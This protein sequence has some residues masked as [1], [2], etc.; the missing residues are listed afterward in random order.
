[1]LSLN[2]LHITAD[3]KEIVKGVTLN[4][5]AGEVHVI[6]GPNGS[7]KSTLANTIMGHPKYTVTTGTITFNNKDITQARP[8][9]RA[10]AG[11]FL[12]MQYPPS[13]AGVT[14]SQFLRAAYNATHTPAFSVMEF[15]KVLREKIDELEIDR[16][17]IKRNINEGFSGGEK[18]RIEILQLLV[19]EPRFAILDETDSGLDVDALK[20]V[21]NGVKQFATPKRGVFI[22]THYARLLEFL[23]PNAVHIMREG[24]IVRTDGAELALEIE[25]KGFEK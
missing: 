8:D 3:N 18:K 7:G 2:N 11:L 14:I 1:M 15:N 16:S 6:M 19:L 25:K 12:S 4:V 17:F 22:I 24:N 5:P 9:E 21:M 10:R 23:K 13:I 20:V